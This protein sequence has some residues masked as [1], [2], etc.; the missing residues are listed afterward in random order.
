MAI[1]L[2]DLLDEK[3][4]DLDLR[5]RRHGNSAARNRSAPGRQRADS[6]SRQ[7]FSNKCWPGSERIPSV[8]EHDVAFPHARTDLVDK[9]VL[10]IGRSRGRNSVWTEAAN[11]PA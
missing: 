9:I 3:Q 5:T 1:A 7:N 8:V 11:A 6:T 4:V 2:A 10:G